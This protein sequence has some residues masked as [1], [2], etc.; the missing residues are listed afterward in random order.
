MGLKLM[1]YYTAEHSLEHS[2]SLMSSGYS[3]LFID[4]ELVIDNTLPHW[5]PGEFMFEQGSSEQIASVT[6]EKDK[7][8]KIVIEY[9]RISAEISGLRLG[10]QAQTQVDYMSEAIDLAK[11]CDAC[12]LVVGT[13]D[14]WESEGS[15]RTNIHL[16]G[17]QDQLIDA[18]TKVQP[19]TALVINAGAPVAMPW[20]DSCK[21]ILWSWFGGQEYGHAMAD[22]LFGKGEPSG[23]M[24]LSFPAEL[25]DSLVSEHYPGSNLS[26][27]YSEQQNI[28]YR[29]YHDKQVDP[30]VCF[31]HG[32]GY[33]TTKWHD[34]AVTKTAEKDQSDE[35]GEI[36]QVKLKVVNTS[37]RTCNDTVQIYIAKETEG[38]DEWYLAG[39]S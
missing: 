4:N 27:H 19:N 8:Y 1:S 18:I 22:I 34:F 21:A 2:F 39:F 31:G 23:R 25:N 24:P 36:A 11:E 3:K 15:D 32:L 14:D 13:S 37:T 10:I 7:V 9:H 16:P 38:L 35:F 12:I 26:M 5:Q 17:K 33:G 20:I 29:W 30:L 28:G 6:L